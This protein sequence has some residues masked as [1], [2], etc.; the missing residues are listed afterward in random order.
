MGQ[1]QG[2]EAQA[3]DER[4][5]LGKHTG[6]GGKED[7]EP[8]EPRS[9]KAQEE[10]QRGRKSEIISLG[11]RAVEECKGCRQGEAVRSGGYETTN[12]HALTRIWEEDAGYGGHR[13][14]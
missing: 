5:G 4:E 3:E 13:N 12:E 14:R 1:D 9:H 7:E 11:K 6:R 10:D 2:Q 8:A